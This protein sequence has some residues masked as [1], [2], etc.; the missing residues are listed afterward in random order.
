MKR[1]LQ[2]AVVVVTCASSGIGRATATA[3]CPTRFLRRIGSPDGKASYSN[4]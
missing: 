2:D 3:F 4:G 1:K